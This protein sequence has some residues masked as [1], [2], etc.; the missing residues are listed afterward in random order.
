MTCVPQPEVVILEQELVVRL[1][2]MVEEPNVV[3]SELALQQA[4]NKLCLILTRLLTFLKL[5][6]RGNFRLLDNFVHA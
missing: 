1:G 6:Y 5:P 4:S 2:H 3:L